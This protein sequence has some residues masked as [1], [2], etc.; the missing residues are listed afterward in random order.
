MKQSSAK[1]K[2]SEAVESALGL[3]QFISYVVTYIFFL[4]IVGDW[5]SST[6]LGEDTKVNIMSGVGIGTLLLI[7]WAVYVKNEK[8]ND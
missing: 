4:V 8:K 3:L 5:L 1:S 7:A 6:S 2:V